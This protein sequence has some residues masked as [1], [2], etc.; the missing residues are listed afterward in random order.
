MTLRYEETVILNVL[1][2]SPDMGKTAV[3]KVLFILQQVKGINLGYDFSIYTYGPYCSDI[4]EDVD[5]LI[6]RNLITSSMYPYQNYIGY[7]LNVTDIWKNNIKQLQ[8]QENE[9]LS[10]VLNFVNGKSAKDLELYSTIIY[11]DSLYSK[12][13]WKKAATSIVKKIKELKPHFEETTINDAY[14]TL[15]QINYLHV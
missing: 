8:N 4:T 6:S 12:N 1:Y 11:V 3:M 10:D 15:L 5:G 13:N 9:A 14:E 7:K 2:Q